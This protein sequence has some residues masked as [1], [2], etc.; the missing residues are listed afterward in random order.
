MSNLK[1]IVRTLLTADRVASGFEPLTRGVAAVFMMHRFADPDAGV[2]GHDPE[3][4][5]SFL[6]HLKRKR[7][8][9][10]SVDDLCKRL[11]AGKPLFKTVAFT[12]DDGYGDFSRVAAPIFAEFDCPATVFLTTGFLDGS[13]WL[14]WDQVAWSFANAGGSEFV[15]DV[16]SRRLRYRWR[17]EPTRRAAAAALVARLKRVPDGEKHACLARLSEALELPIPH[18]PPAQFAPM[19][20][21]EVRAAGRQGITFG[22]HTVTHP[23]LAETPPSRAEW[24]M[25]ESWARVRAETDAAVPVF[26]YPNG[27]ARS[28]GARD[29]ALARALGFDAAVSGEPGYAHQS[30]FAQSQPD[31]RFM[32][33]RFSF[34]DDP[35]AN[36]QV[37][38]GVERLKMAIRPARR[39]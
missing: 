12:V 6:E 4:L 37:I 25:R 38:S 2:P 13:L 34:S 26:C 7:Y 1:R 21:D 35:S 28:F 9:F 3:Q 15:L 23:I 30:L 18:A 22:P 16:G 5:R 32:I 33:P 19:N 17:D 31:A 27:D 24:E 29:I 20:W 8:Q 36:L 14:W 11:R 39:P 10:V